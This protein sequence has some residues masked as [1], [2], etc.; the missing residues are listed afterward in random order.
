MIVHD[1]KNP[2]NSIIGLT[3]V[4]LD[5]ETKEEIKEN[6]VVD[7][8]GQRVSIDQVKYFIG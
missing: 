5:E 7:W 4:K 6:E 1:L 8:I 2:L 3:E